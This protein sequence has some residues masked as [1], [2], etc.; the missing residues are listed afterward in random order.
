MT[1]LDLL[2]TLVLMQPRIQLA[3]WAGSAHC[4]LMSNFSSTSVPKSCKQGE[5]KQIPP[6]RGILAP[7]KVMRVS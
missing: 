3:F 7:R 6:S 2:A 1:S 5:A 4:Q